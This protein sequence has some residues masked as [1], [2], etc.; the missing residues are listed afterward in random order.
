MISISQVLL[1][2]R[3]G[4]YLQKLL[5]QKLQIISKFCKIIIQCWS[6]LYSKTIKWF[7][8]KTP[9]QCTV[10]FTNS[11]GNLHLGLE[12]VLIELAVMHQQI[13]ITIH[14]QN[15]IISYIL[16]LLL[17]Q[18][19]MYD[20][21][22]QLQFI[23]ILEIM[24]IVNRFLMEINFHDVQLL[25]Q[26]DNVYI[27]QKHQVMI[28]QMNVLIM[29]IGIISFTLTNCAN[30]AYWLNY[31]IIIMF[32]VLLFSKLCIYIFKFIMLLEWIQLYKYDLYNNSRNYRFRSLLLLCM[33][34][35]MYS[36]QTN[37]L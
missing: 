4:L 7:K 32:L 20:Y 15:V 37:Y 10:T 17:L 21:I 13:Q 12:L 3:L 6:W 18:V 24:Q 28:I 27:H 16:V 23:H 25:V 1:F 35:F 22:N 2:F 34:D 29:K 31:I 9:K 19:K 14:L 26:T 8:I 30:C 5:I 11:S 36:K 33:D